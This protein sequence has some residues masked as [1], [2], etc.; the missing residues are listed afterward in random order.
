MLSAGEGPSSWSDYFS[1]QRRWSRGTFEILSWTFWRRFP[2]LSPGGM[3]HYTLITT[4]YPSMA[5][6]W[7]LGIVNTVLF[8]G[9]GVSGMTISPQLWFALYTDA[10]AFSLWLYINNRQYNVSPYES[11]DSRGIKGM[12]MSI[13][14]APIYAVQL[15]STL[16]RRP[17]RFV[18]TP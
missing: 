14:S 15:L 10:T 8:L 5:L 11:P 2:R 1:Q 7:L 9:L 18:V 4:F 16:G 12:L 13:I 3:L 17:A 6:G